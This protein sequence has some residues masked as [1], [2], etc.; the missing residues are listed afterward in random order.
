MA[1]EDFIPEIWSAR[2]LKHLDKNLVFKQLVNTDYE[3]EIRNF[4][5]TVRVNRIGDITVSPYTGT[6][7]DPQALTGD[8]A[9]L[10]IN[11]ASYFNFFVDDVTEAQANPK[12]MDAAMERAAFALANTVDQY[13]AGLH[14][15]AGIVLDKGGDGYA[16]GNSNGKTNPY[17]LVIDI[18]EKMD[19][20]NVPAA[21]RWLVIPPWFHAALLKSEEYKLAFQ[22]YKTSGEIP[23]IAGIKI[24]ASNNLKTTTIGT[25]TYHI[26][27]AG[28]NMAISFAQQLSKVEAY[29]PE[30][31]F[32]DAVKGLLLYGAKAFYPESLVKIVAKKA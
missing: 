28:T 26:L 23:T 4:G 32:A 5:D 3:G 30:K 16:V 21:G 24:L 17:D 1:L 7:A 13:I 20:N 14:A 15:Q 22:D 25:A 11:E 10:E 9:V 2:L 19:E 12:L 31:K 29:R 8:Q 6:V 18:V 27:L